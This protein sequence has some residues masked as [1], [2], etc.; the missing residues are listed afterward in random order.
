MWGESF[1]I[2]AG[3]LSAIL[4]NVLDADCIFPFLSAPSETERY[5]PVS[6]LAL[7][8]FWY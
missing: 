3:F 2:K 4:T 7:I 1:P 6:L 8:M 5:A